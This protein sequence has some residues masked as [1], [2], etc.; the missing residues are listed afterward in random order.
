MSI[1]EGLLQVLQNRKSKLI[2]KETA[3]KWYNEIKRIKK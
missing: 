2:S 3:R 1:Q